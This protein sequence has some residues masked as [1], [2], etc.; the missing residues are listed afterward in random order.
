MG[1]LSSD[2]ARRV[3][4]SLWSIDWISDSEGYMGCPGG[5]RH[6]RPDGA[7]DCR[8][9]LEGGKPP[10][11]HCVHASCGHEIADANF[12]LR[13]ALGK[14]ENTSGW[15]PSSRDW[16]PEAPAVPRE[17]PPEYVPEKLAAFAGD[18]AKIVDIAWLA[19]RSVVEP[20]Q[21]STQDFLAALYRPVQGERVLVFT[22]EFSQGEAVWPDKPLPDRGPKGVWFLCQPVDGEFRP[23]PRSHQ[24]KYGKFLLDENGQ[25]IP[26]MSRRSEESVRE[27]RFMVLESDQAPAR[28]WLGALV[29][30]PLRVA[31]IYTSGG[32]SIH[33]LIR[34]DAR[35]KEEWERT[36]MALKAGLVTLGADPGSMS[37]VRLTRLPGC[38]REGKADRDGNV[39]KFP[40]PRYQKLLYL[41][42]DPLVR[43]IAEIMPRRDV[44]ADVSA[45]GHRIAKDPAGAT[46]EEMKA[47]Q[48][49]AW[50]YAPVCAQFR[51]WAEELESLINE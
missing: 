35:I 17:A 19:N 34:I 47:L 27:Y 45:E 8:I 11:I 33:V 16:K 40:E 9:M 3:A 18:W 7:R 41:N 22:D 36:K 13:S 10:T 30:L 49:R 43:P 5:G 4:E 14:A 2:E 29:Q 12:L 32:K 25:K 31:A 15:T 48:H 28:Q 23:N 44:L 24:K 1:A 46:I 20:S 51:T 26:V 6:T 21:A 42:P 39:V 38:W 37:G 50:Y